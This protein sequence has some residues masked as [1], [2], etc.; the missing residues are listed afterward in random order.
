MHLR[1][2]PARVVVRPF[3]ISRAE[4]TFTVASSYEIDL[5]TTYAYAIYRDSVG[6]FIGGTYGF[7][8][9]IPAGGQAAGTVTSYEP[10]AGV[11]TTD[12]YVDQ[13]YF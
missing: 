10:V 1:P 6:E 7:V 9:L 13:G 4:T 8:D 5:E 12:V 2:D 11:A 3:R